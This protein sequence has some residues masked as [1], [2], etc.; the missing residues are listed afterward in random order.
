MKSEQF[1]DTKVKESSKPSSC[2]V[3]VNLDLVDNLKEL[4]CDI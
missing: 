2:R 1:Y 4:D 3:E